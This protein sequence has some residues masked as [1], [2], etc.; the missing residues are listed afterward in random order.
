MTA[1][2]DRPDTGADDARRNALRGEYPTLQAMD[3]R[4]EAIRSEL[5]A[6][7]ALDAPEAD[8]LA[9]QGTLIQEF[10]DLDVIATGPRKR[11]K[12]LKRVLAARQDPANAE[13]GADT[14]PV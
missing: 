7:D 2:D 12:D 9:W 4:Q 13:D 6:L 10:D 3:A 11:A 1:V 5:A 8:D 14:G